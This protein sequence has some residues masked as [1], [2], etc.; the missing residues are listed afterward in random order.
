MSKKLTL[1]ENFLKEKQSVTEEELSSLISKSKLSYDDKEE[2]SEFIINNNIKVIE[3]NVDE[4]EYVEVDA[5][6]DDIKAIE[7][8]DNIKIDE[9]ILADEIFKA[10]SSAIRLYLKEISRIP[11]LTPE[12]ELEL[13][14]KIADG[15]EEAKKKMI[16]A[17]LRLVVHIAKK[18]GSGENFMD[19]IQEG[20]TGLIKAVDKFDYTLGYKFSTYATWW[21]RQAIQRAYADQSRTIRIP[22]HLHEIMVRMNKIER[23]YIQTHNGED[24]P[25]EELAKALSSATQT[26]DVEKVREIKKYAYQVDN[27]SL[28]LPV[29]EDKDTTLLQMVEDDVD[30]EDE[31]MQTVIHNEILK[32]INESNLTDREK[33]VALR[34]GGFYGRR[35]TLQEIAKDYGLTRERIR[36]IEQKAY[37][38]LRGKSNGPKLKTLL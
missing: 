15:D 3:N 23:D 24:M 22:V 14:K 28:D 36:Q 16:E 17:N 33:D 25:L 8:N 13:A 34:R 12:E 11:L 29:G 4:F 1:V 20:N 19:S 26:F 21:I 18:Y 30:V 38:K 2:L 6:K 37:R 31:I 10:D 32:I 7:E 27:T 35:E 5:T 9:N